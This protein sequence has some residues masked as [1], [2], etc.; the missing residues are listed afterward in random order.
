MLLSEEEECVFLS[1][2]SVSIK[3]LVENATELIMKD[4]L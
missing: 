2:Y 4:I 1:R 3:G